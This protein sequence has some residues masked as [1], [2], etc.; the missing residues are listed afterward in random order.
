[1]DGT[2]P[3]ARASRT[4]TSRIDRRLWE[5]AL[6]G[7]I[8]ASMVDAFEGAQVT[9]TEHLTFETIMCLS[10]PIEALFGPLH[11]H[12]V[13]SSNGN[14]L[15]KVPHPDGDFILGC[16]ATKH[17]GIFHLSGSVPTTDR[18]WKRVNTAIGGAA[19][20]MRCFLDETMFRA[21]AA[22]S[23]SEGLTEVIRMT[24][25][26]QSD[27]SSLNRSWQ[28]KVGQRRH[29]PLEVFDLARSEGT[30]VRTLTVL[31]EDVAHCHLRRT[32]GSTFY[33]G[34]VRS[35]IHRVLDPLARFSSERLSLLA[36]RNRLINEPLRPPVSVALSESV[37]NSGEDTGRL[38]SLIEELP[39]IS[40]AVLH[41][42]PYLH[43][44]VA[45]HNDGSTFDVVITNPESVDIYPSFRAS[46]PSLARLAQTIAA[47]FSS[48][49]IEEARRE[50]TFT[51]EDLVGA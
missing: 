13:F 11:S 28:A 34:D 4:L 21:L 48:S 19:E 25:W 36:N 15:V 33:S 26:R 46:A 12:Q 39:K 31:A 23:L 5:S 47:H 2:T 6:G 41:G 27:S 10:D 18:R 16:W 9:K 30:S 29:T 17:S 7:R 43:L 8:A 14:Q 42:N 51:L 50:E 40:V 49:S 32:S 44:M 3:S 24:A 22:E 20:I 45:D 1:M 37:F 35:F 38:Q